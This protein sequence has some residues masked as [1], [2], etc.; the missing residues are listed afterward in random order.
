MKRRLLALS[1]AVIML[2]S[3]FTITA[4]AADTNSTAASES[5]L[6]TYLTKKV[7]A[8]NI[9]LN[10]IN[11]AVDRVNKDIKQ[12]I[13][14]GVIAAAPAGT[15]EETINKAIERAY[16]DN[17]L[18]SSVIIATGRTNLIEK[19]TSDISKAK[20]LL[21]RYS[22]KNYKSLFS[23][24]V[25][26]WNYVAIEIYFGLNAVNAYIQMLNSIKTPALSI[27]YAGYLKDAAPAPLDVLSLSEGMHLDKYGR[28]IVEYYVGGVHGDQF[29]EYGKSL[30]VTA[31]WTDPDTGEISDIAGTYVNGGWNLVIPHTDNNFGIYTVTLSGPN[32]VAVT[33]AYDLGARPV[34]S[35]SGDLV[36]DF[37]GMYYAPNTYLFDAAGKQVGY[38]ETAN[39]AVFNGLTAG[40]YTVKLMKNGLVK[41][42]TVNVEGGDK[43]TTFV[44]PLVTLTVVQPNGVN[45]ACNINVVPTNGSG[46][47]AYSQSGDATVT[48]QKVFPGE[49]YTISFGGGMNFTDTFSIGEI[50]YTYTVPTATVTVDTKGIEYGYGM[51][52]FITNDDNGARAQYRQVLANQAIE[53]ELIVGKSYTFTLNVGGNTV[54]KTM[55]VIDGANV[56]IM[57]SE[58]SEAA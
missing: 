22:Y 37:S 43:T 11:T 53:V 18:T 1:L 27:D 10:V 28:Y 8:L 54:V 15:S 29:N 47:I 57:G 45:Y 50:D 31:T 9:G 48:M 26:G 32:A 58:V 49:S 5:E 52:L 46:N 40:S 21:G 56:V 41:E 51:N 7:N 25:T 39:T 55:T 4:S 36:V 17:K 12:K 19:M 16:D 38:A 20:N 44:V 24:T 13:T 35:Q 23:N 2:L 3:L 34:V 30:T 42:Y 6:V 14:A 33:K